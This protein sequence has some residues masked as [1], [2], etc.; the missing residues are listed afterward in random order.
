MRGE[1]GHFDRPAPADQI[2]KYCTLTNATNST[3]HA[4]IEITIHEARLPSTRSFISRN[5]NNTIKRILCIV[6]MVFAVITLVLSLAGIVGAWVLRSELNQTLDVVSSL[7][8]TALQRARNGVARI[9]PPLAKAL[10]VVQNTESRVRQ[11]GQT[12]Q[13]TNLI[14]AGAERLLNQDLSTE[15]NTLTTTL[16]AASETLQ[17]A[18]DTLNALNRLP[19]I[20]GEVGALSQARQLLAELQSI[21]Q[22]IR[23]TWQALQVKK[24]NTIQT[25]VNT[26]TAPLV[27]LNTLLTTVGEHSQNIQAR[28]SLVE[29]RVP[30]VVG[31]AKTIIL[32]IVI[33]VTLA[34]AWM[35]ITQVIVFKFSLD[36]YRA[37]ASKPISADAA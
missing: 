10:T 4:G 31:Q 22:T 37:P 6:A 16:R 30:I 15:V 25:V 32:L 8:V 24:D 2:I 18:E 36:R 1:F 33:V 26:L 9:D 3:T 23:D 14:I 19:F 12:L 35:V 21:E 28:L 13:D 34:L 20:N 27:R 29:L 17:A 11:S 5:M 7:S